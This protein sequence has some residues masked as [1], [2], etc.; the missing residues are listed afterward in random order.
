MSLV[1]DGMGEVY[2]ALTMLRKYS[3]RA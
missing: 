1:A 3:I 2:R